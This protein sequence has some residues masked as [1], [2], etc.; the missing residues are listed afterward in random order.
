MN[1]P[2]I[3]I[4]VAEP[5]GAGEVQA[6]YTSELPAWLGRV[7]DLKM[8]KQQHSIMFCQQ[9]IPLS[10]ESRRLLMDYIDKK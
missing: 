10:L 3:L 5:N 2:S 4:A 7:M 6:L 9:E 8:L 1:N